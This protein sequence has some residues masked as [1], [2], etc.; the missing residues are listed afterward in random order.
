MGV[1]AEWRAAKA[2]VLRAGLADLNEV[3]QSMTLG[4][5][6]AYRGLSVDY[7]FGM[8]SLG[9]THRVS[10]S[11]SFGPTAAAL[12]LPAPV[13]DPSPSTSGAVTR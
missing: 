8:H 10:L 1:G 4:L 3:T 12:A 2:L 13:L 6:A 9:A 11:W 5:S 7:A